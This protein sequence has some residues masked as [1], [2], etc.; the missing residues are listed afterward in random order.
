MVESRHRTRWHARIPAWLTFVRTGK[1]R[2]EIRHFLR[3]MKFDE[4]AE[5]GERLLAQAARQFNLS[6]GNGQ[7]RRSGTT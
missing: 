2:S 3:T 4:S 5:L 6:P 1:A 7:R